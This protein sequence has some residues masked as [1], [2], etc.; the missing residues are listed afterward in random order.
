MEGHL[1]GAE[2]SAHFPHVGESHAFP[3]DVNGFPGHVIEAKHHVLGRHD[4]RLAAGRGQ[5]VVRGHHE[6]P[7]L[8]LS[9]K[10]QGHVHG[11]L[12]AVEVR[13]VRRADEGMKLNSL[14]LNEHG[15]E[16]LDAETVQRRRPVQEHGVFADDVGKDIPHLRGLPLNHLLGCLDGGRQ[17]ASL[18]LSEDKGLEELKGHFLRQTALVQLEGRPHHDNGAARVI[19]ALPEQVLTET[20]LLTLDH[21]RKGLQRPLVRTGNSTTATTVIQQR[22]HRFLEHALLVAHDDVRR[23]EIKQALQTV[24]PVDHPAI[25]IVQIR[26]REAAAVQ[27]HEGPKVRGQHRQHIHHHPLGLVPRTLEGLHELQALGQ[28]LDLGFGVR[29]RDLFP[30]N[31][32]LLVQVQLGQQLKDRLCAHFRHKIVAVLLERLV[33]LLVAEQLANFQIRSAVVDHHEGLEVEHALDIPKGHIE[34][35]ANP[36]RQ[37]LQEPDVRDGAGQLDVAHA[38]PAHLGQGHFHATLF[39][40]HAAMLQAL[41]LPAEALVVLDGPE[42]AGAEKAVALRLEGPVVDGFRLLHFPEGPGTNHFRGRQA[43]AQGIKIIRLGLGLQQIQ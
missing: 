11:H 15:L 37:G 39:A 3:G 6:R 13:V 35:Q 5:N 32:D 17:A 18:E 22:I 40:N 16:G 20:T 26:G 23:A 41:V 10:G 8:E 30:K 21:I 2:R 14:A 31:I 38:L 27:G 33:I 28:L 7:C 43:D 19:D 36:G 29:L 9:F 12:V 4:D 25:Q 1:T 24:I 34:K 42:N